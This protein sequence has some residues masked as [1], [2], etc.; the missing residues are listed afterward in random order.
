MPREERPRV[1]GAS[2]GRN[3][4]RRRDFLKLG[5]AGV[6]ALSLPGIPFGALAQGVGSG[7][8]A[9]GVHRATDKKLLMV[10]GFRNWKNAT[11]VD[12]HIVEYQ[13]RRPFLDG[14][15]FHTGGV[16]DS[17]L[18]M[19]ND[20][21]LT[22][23]T[24]K[25]DRLRSIA[26]KWNRYTDNFLAVYGYS[27]N[28]NPDWFDE[29]LWGRIRPNAAL[30]AKAARTGRCK[31]VVFDPEVYATDYHSPWVYDHD[32]VA[33]FPGKTFEE[34]AVKARQRG[35]EFMDATQSEFPGLV[36]FTLFGYETAWTY[37]NTS[38]AGG[39]LANSRYALLAPFMDGLVEAADPATTIVQGNEGSYYLDEAR[40]YLENNTVEAASYVYNRVVAP[41]NVA[42]PNLMEKFNAQVQI[43]MAPA[44]DFCLGNWDWYG[45]PEGYRRRWFKHNVY[46]SLLTSDQ[47]V[48][49]WFEGADFFDDD[50]T[51]R[52]VT[53]REMADDME[54]AL[55]GFRSG[56]RL[57]YEMVKNKYFE[58]RA[59]V[60]S[61]LLSSPVA[62]ITNPANNTAVPRQRNVRIALRVA[63]ATSVDRVVFY[64]N[65]LKIGEVPKAPYRLTH[66]FVPGDHT[67]LARVFLDGQKGQPSHVSSNPVFLTAGQRARPT[68][69]CPQQIVCLAPVTTSPEGIA[70]PHETESGGGARRRPR[71][72][73][74]RYSITSASTTSVP[75]VVSPMSSAATCERSRSRPATYG[76]RSLTRTTVQST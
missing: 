32:G 63:P 18:I 14:I 47:Y 12:A 52:G 66:R 3:G 53:M 46:H 49:V 16:E 6:A 71:I 7:S 10:N 30:F 24:V 1:E 76:P 19:F 20:A 23:R 26:G 48:W 11:D 36:F 61:R 8:T 38:E 56:E 39:S 15:V 45:H 44:P 62:T 57:G 68:I 5:G 22:E 75:T 2:G 55:S 41:R 64:V 40:K 60:R 42:A 21:V 25:M 4:I 27:T 74:D 35:R 51:V 59:D 69:A 34:V 72:T 13:N 29:A 28:K 70:H 37:A 50:A 67:V 65:S 31:G 58:Y 43:A 73:S 33:P 54:A 9:T 17:A